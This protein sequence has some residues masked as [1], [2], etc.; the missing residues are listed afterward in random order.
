MQPQPKKQGER[1]MPRSPHSK[2]SKKL[3][4]KAVHENKRWRDKLIKKSKAKK[5]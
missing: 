1:I 3:I 2:K 4:G 5:A